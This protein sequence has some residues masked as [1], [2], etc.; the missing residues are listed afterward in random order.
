LFYPTRIRP[1]AISRAS[2]EWELRLDTSCSVQTLNGK[3]HRSPRCLPEL[4]APCLAAGWYWNEVLARDARRRDPGRYGCR[5]R[6]FSE[7]TLIWIA[8]YS[9]EGPMCNYW[10]H[11]PNILAPR[12]PSLCPSGRRCP[13]DLPAGLTHHPLLSYYLAPTSFSL[14]WILQQDQD[15]A[16]AFWAVGLLHGRTLSLIACQRSVGRRGC[17]EMCSAASRK[18]ST[19]RPRICSVTT[20]LERQGYVL[21]SNPSGEQS[22]PRTPLVRWQQ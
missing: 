7:N 1:V 5:R 12:S 21:G 11:D 18:T 9:N 10:D 17:D 19:Q 2:D 13:P 20:L 8:D 22:G 4:H 15:D 14:V 16:D 3:L 6:I